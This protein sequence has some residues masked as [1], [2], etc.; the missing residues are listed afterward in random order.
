MENVMT[1][2]HMEVNN[3]NTQKLIHHPLY[4]ILESTTFGERAVHNLH[5]S[6]NSI[7]IYTIFSHNP[8]L[9]VEFNRKNK[10]ITFTYSDIDTF[11]LL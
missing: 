8:N 2:N 7:G 6:L 3:I 9:K 10:G 4:H 11:K 1:S 5:L